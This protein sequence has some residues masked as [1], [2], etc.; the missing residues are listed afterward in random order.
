M[1]QING[2][3]RHGGLSKSENIRGKRPFRRVPNP[4]LANP[5]VAEIAVRASDYWVLTRV[6]TVRGNGRNL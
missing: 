5:R 3:L 2:G 4:P 1:P 6:S